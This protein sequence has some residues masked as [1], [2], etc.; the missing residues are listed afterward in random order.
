MARTSRSLRIALTCATRRRLEV[1]TTAPGGNDSS[2]HGSRA[3]STSNGMAR[4]GTQATV[5]P[6]VSSVGRSFRLWTAASIRRSSRA[7]SS[8]RTHTPS[9][10]IAEIGTSSRRSPCVEIVTTS[11]ACPWLRSWSTTHPVCVRASR[12][13]RVPT[14]IGRSCREVSECV[15]MPAYCSSPPRPTLEGVPSLPAET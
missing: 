3:T 13:A 8:S 4:T 10:P 6:G 11:T 12:L 2:V 1:P 14:R 7:R 15:C 9:P 5:S